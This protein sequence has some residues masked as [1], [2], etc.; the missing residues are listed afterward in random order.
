MLLGYW[1]DPKRG[2]RAAR[3]ARRAR[4]SPPFVNPE[5]VEQREYVA[6]DREFDD[7]E[8]EASPGIF[9]S[10]SGFGPDPNREVYATVAPTRAAEMEAEREF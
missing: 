3:N 4:V 7:V 1:R 5:P 8:V 9:V 6:V 10:R 2:V